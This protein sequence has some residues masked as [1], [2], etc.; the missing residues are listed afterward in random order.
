MGYISF[1]KNLATVSRIEFAPMN[2]INIFI[3]FFLAAS[4][5]ADLQPL[6]AFEIV[7]I[8]FLA[9]WFGSAINC[10]YDKDIDEKYKTHLANA[11]DKLGSALRAN[12]FD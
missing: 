6:I 10:L 11:V 5:L 1:G 12:T 7:I 8:W 2:L 3:P 4:S 9:F